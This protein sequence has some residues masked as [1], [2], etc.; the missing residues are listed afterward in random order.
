P[1]DTEALLDGDAYLSGTTVES[2]GVHLLFVRSVDAAGNVSE[3]SIS[4]E[5]DRTPPV[6]H[7]QSP[8]AGAIVR[9]AYVDVV[10]QTEALPSVELAVG[11]LL[12]SAQ[13]GGDGVFAFSDVALELGDN[14]IAVRA[15]DRAGNVGGW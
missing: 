15:T 12:V 8:T 7:L 14:P 1:V 2:E 10:G 4:F 13:A 6:V 11:A 3:R 5:I 9:R